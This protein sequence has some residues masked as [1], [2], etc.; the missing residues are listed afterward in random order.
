MQRMPYT[1][2]DIVISFHERAL[3]NTLVPLD[4]VLW[5]ITTAEW[6]YVCL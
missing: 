5:K 6:Y 1:Q 2:T 4:M 3:Y